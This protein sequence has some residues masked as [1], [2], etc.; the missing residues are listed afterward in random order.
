L[1]NLAII[2]TIVCSISCSTHIKTVLHKP[3]LLKEPEIITVLRTQ[4]ME[5]AI[6]RRDPE[7]LKHPTEIE[8]VDI[9]EYV[10]SLQ[11]SFQK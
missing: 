8:L 9:V 6:N 1:V 4:I 7:S 3:K 5:I 10:D 11:D 2:V